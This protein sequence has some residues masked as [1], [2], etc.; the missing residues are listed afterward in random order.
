MR[1]CVVGVGCVRL[2]SGA[3]FVEAEGEMGVDLE[4]DLRRRQIF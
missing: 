3:C 2:V 1:L 4:A